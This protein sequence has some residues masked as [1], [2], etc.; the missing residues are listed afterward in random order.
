MHPLIAKLSLDGDPELLHERRGTTFFKVS[1]TAL[2]ITSG[3]MAGRE[4]EV[5]A[6]L[7][8]D[9]YRAHG[10]YGDGTWLT[11]RWIDGTSLWDAL[12]PAHRGGDT[13]AM[14]RAV[15]TAA[16]GAAEALA[17]LHAGGWTHGDLQPDHVVFEDDAVR[18]IDLACAQGPVPVPFYVHRGGLAHTTAPE[19]AAAILDTTDHISTTPEADV[20]SLAASLFWSWTRIPPTNYRDPQGCRTDLLPDIAAGR[21]HD[22]EAVRPLPFPDFEGVMEFGLAHEPEQRPSARSLAELLRVVAP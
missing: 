20:W 6:A 19:T 2:K 8:A 4:G 13:P 22:L 5:L 15:L 12:G 14:R 1:D 18:I 7:G 10:R 11:M 21:Q 16:T 3:L 9:H 17:E